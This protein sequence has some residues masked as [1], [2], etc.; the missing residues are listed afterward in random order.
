MIHMASD[1]AT[2]ITVYGNPLAS[3][4]HHQNQAMCQVLQSALRAGLVS[5]PLRGHADCLM[6]LLLSDVYALQ[7]LFAG[8]FV[9]PLSSVKLGPRYVSGDSLADELTRCRGSPGDKPLAQ[10]GSTKRK[11]ACVWS[12]YMQLCLHVVTSLLDGAPG[13]PM[14]GPLRNLVSWR[15]PGGENNNLPVF[16]GCRIFRLRIAAP[17]PGNG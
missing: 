13:T 9:M 16:E 1:F 2:Y 11:Y 3:L 5:P 15:A 17:T 12:Y 4:S 7:P 6:A 8:S 14:E 10:S